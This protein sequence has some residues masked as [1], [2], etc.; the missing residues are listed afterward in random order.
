M[1]ERKFFAPIVFAFFK[2]HLRARCNFRHSIRPRTNGQL[3]RGRLNVAVFVNMFWQNRHKANN[4]R[5]FTVWLGAVE[6]KNRRVLVRGLK[7]QDLVIVMAMIGSPLVFQ[8]VPSERNIRGGNWRAVAKAC[9]LAQFKS[10]ARA[11]GRGG[12]AF[13]Q[14]SVKR[15]GLAIMAVEKAS[16]TRWRIL[17]A[18]LPRIENGL[19][20]SKLPIWACFSCP[21]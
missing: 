10:N 5:Q 12:N 3:E 4:Q 6:V 13:C 7:S 8:Q 15:K 9:R 20:L 17:R 14:Q 18:A 19:R 16:K 2:P 21:P 11:V 1:V